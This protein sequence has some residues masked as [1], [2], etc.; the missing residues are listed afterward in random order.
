MRVPQTFWITLRVE[1]L[2]LITLL[3]YVYSLGLYEFRG[4]WSVIKNMWIHLCITSHV[5]SLGTSIRAEVMW[6]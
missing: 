2:T 5:Q 4:S 6:T 3:L 1:L